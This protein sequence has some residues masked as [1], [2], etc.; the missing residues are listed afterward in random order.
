MFDDLAIKGVSNLIVDLRDNRGGRDDYALY[1]LSYLAKAPFHY[2]LS[3]KAATDHFT[4]LSYTNQEEALNPLM[5]QIVTKG[6]T[7]SFILRNTHPT[8]NIKYPEANRFTGKIY[9]ITN[10][11]TF[12]AAAD[13]AAIANELK[14]G[15]FIGE[16]TGG[17]SEGN[18]SN[19]NINPAKFRNKDR[20]S[21][22]SD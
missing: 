15:E 5:S 3:L 18:T 19:G 17:A 13:F 10:G 6:S 11:N 21:N 12:S 4:F 2:H 16:E 20:Y 8:L 9:F 22:F 1:L 14:L 7:G